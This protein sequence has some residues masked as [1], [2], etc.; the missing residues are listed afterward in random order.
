MT[1]DEIKEFKKS[2][3]QA[4]D[5]LS[6]FQ[7]HVVAARDTLP[8][9]YSAIAM[10]QKKLLENHINSEEGR[11]EDIRLA[12]NELREE[13]KDYQNFVAGIRGIRMFGQG[14]LIFAAVIAS[15]WGLF[16]IINRV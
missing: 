9:T 1:R 14:F 15:L 7:K 12:I 13:I 5:F 4:K 3:D 8:V 2:V 11:L 10:E 16:K 6:L